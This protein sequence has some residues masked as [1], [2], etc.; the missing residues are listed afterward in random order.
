MARY[1]DGGRAVSL[2]VELLNT[3]SELLLGNVRDAH[4]SWFGQQLFPI[5]LRISRQTTVPDG[6]PIRDALLETPGVCLSAAHGASGDGS[7]GGNR[8]S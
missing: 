6:A 4:L 5:G 3:G 7:R 8:S 1:R 2:R